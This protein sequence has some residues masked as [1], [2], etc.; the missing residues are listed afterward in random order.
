MQAG[1]LDALTPMTPKSVSSVSSDSTDL[2]DDPD[3]TVVEMLLEPNF[4][5]VRAPLGCGLAEAG[6]GEAA[7]RPR[8]RRRRQPDVR[9]P[10]PAPPTTQAAHP[11]A[12]PQIDNTYN[13]LQTLCEYIDDTEVGPPRLCCRRA[14]TVASAAAQASAAGAA[15]PTSRP[16]ALPPPA[17][18]STH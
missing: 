3:V 16:T 11:P 4:L 2:E 13:K 6:L 14:W 15:H 17:S 10:A 1:A 18:V 7:A 5:Q 8:R 9:L 12:P